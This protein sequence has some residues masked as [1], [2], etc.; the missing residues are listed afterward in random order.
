MLT[1]VRSFTNMKFGPIKILGV[2]GG[3]S[4]SASVWDIYKVYAQINITHFNNTIYRCCMKYKSHTLA[5]DDSRTNITY[6]YAEYKELFGL[7]HFVCSNKHNELGVRPVGV[8]ITASGGTCS[9]ED[10]VFIEPYHPLRQ[11]GSKLVIGAKLAYANIS[12]MSIVEWMESN[13]YLG[14][15]K[16]VAYYLSN[17]NKDAL[18]VLNYYATTG[19][20]DL[21]LFKPPWAGKNYLSQLNHSSRSV[22]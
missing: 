1:G 11:P 12:A 18:K 3:N 5:V 17:L 8:A 10:V 19:F 13:K 14:V 22:D 9:E 7:F 4:S 6:M 20:I 21:Y 15:D 2:V 16:I